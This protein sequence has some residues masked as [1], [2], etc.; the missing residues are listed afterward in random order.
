MGHILDTYLM[1]KIGASKLQNEFALPTNEYLNYYKL[2]SSIPK[3]WQRQFKE[4]IIEMNQEPA[5]FT[6]IKSQNQ[7]NICK[8]MTDFQIRKI[9]SNEKTK[10]QHKWESCFEDITFD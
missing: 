2:I 8:Y 7:Y 5:L 1:I 9:N 6:F 4:Q 3:G 10:A